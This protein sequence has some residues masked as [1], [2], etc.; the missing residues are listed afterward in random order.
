MMKSGRVA[1]W[2]AGKGAKECRRVESAFLE[3]EDKTES[4]TIAIGDI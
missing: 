2:N 1:S 3:G 4:M